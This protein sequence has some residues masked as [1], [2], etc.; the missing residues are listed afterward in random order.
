[1]N[2]KF[3]IDN[4]FSNNLKEKRE[5]LFENFTSKSRNSFRLQVRHKHFFLLFGYLGN[6]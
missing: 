1:M 6:I 4:G 5:G 2:L 3:N